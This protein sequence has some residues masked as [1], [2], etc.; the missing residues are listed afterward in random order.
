MIWVTLVDSMSKKQPKSNLVQENEPLEIDKVKTKNNENNEHF[1]VE[2][3]PEMRE[4]SGKTITIE[5]AAGAILGSL[6]IIIGFMFLFGNISVISARYA[7]GDKVE[8][9]ELLDVEGNLFRLSQ[10][11]G[12]VIVLNFFTTW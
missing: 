12:K 3:L 1:T 8:P 2:K 6:S 4:Y 10:H 5:I 7:V 11:E 9:F